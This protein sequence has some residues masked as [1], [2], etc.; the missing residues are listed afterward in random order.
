MILIN[1]SYSINSAND[2]YMFRLTVLITI[3]IIIT[4]GT[5]AT[6]SSA[7]AAIIVVVHH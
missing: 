7:A 2:D 4:A 3:N 5:A 6:V 1:P